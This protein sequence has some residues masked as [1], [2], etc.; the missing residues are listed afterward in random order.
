MAKRSAAALEQSKLL[1]KVP[2]GADRIQV[3]TETGKTRYRKIHELLDT[4]V[5]QVKK[6]GDPIV[7][8][9]SPGRRGEVYIGPA[10]PLVAETLR[11][12]E[13][14]LRDDP[15]RKE[16]T[17]NPE[18]PDVLHQVIVGLSEEAASIHFERQ[19]AERRGDETSILS[20]RRIAALK[21]VGD[22]WLK[23][24]E[25]IQARGVDMDTPAFEAVLRFLLETFK[26]ALDA[27]GVR[28]QMSDTVFAQLGKV[29]DD[30]SW[31]DEAKRRIKNIV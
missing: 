19:Q 16:V 17:E 25:Q 20:N 23:R 2:E 24:R 15:V 7:M 12:K 26:E 8:M 28:P 18:S 10:S 31:K 6:N 4:D 1:K 21:A 13:E 22:T 9:D 5:I 27:C 14:S 29:L 3:K 11:H 30:D